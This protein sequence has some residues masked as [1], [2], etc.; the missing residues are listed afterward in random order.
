MKVIVIEDEPT[1]LMGMKRAIESIELDLSL[2]TSNHA[3]EAIGIIEEHRPDLIVTDIM[4]PGMTGLDLVEHFVSKYYQPK[5]IIVSGYNDFEYAQRS[6]R[7]GAVDYLLKPY[8]TEEFIEKIRKFLLLIRQEKE[9]HDQLL[10]QHTFAQMGKRLMRDNYLSDFCLK[11]TPLEEHIYQRLKLWNLTWLADQPYF[12]MVTDTKGYPDGKPIGRNYDLQTFA[13]GNILN[14]LL[15]GFETTIFFKD[16]KHRWVIITSIDN[17]KELAH[18]IVQSVKSYQ[19]IDLAMGIS[20]KMELFEQIHS[21]YQDALK[22]FRIHSLSDHSNFFCGTVST[23]SSSYATPDQMASLLCE[24]NEESIAQAAN[25]FV[26]ETV[27]L[28]G[29]ESREDIIRNILNYLSQ[30]HVS[31]SEK[32]NK[33]LEEI[34]MSVWEAVD[35]MQHD[36]RISASFA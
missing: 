31:L 7:F 18:S 32:M 16:P 36:S 21:A 19:K 28:E 17:V 4:L 14:E 15:T 34:P 2:F 9:Q 29:T 24:Q 22:A 11:Y 1:S 25:Q 20:A 8:H 27:M 10:Q 6:L 33:D 26:Q 35:E 3:E 23:E 30:I 12:I 5:V 13:I